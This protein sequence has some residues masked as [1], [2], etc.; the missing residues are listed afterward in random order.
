MPSSAATSS[1]VSPID[2]V[3]GPAVSVCTGGAASSRSR[4]R[5]LVKRQPREVSA[6]SPGFAHGVPGLAITQGAR[7]MDSIPPATTTS[8]S[9]ARIDCAAFATA[10]RP[11][12]QRR[13]TV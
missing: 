6:T 3:T 11:L 1:A 13:L 8:A 5:G 4:K 7:V 2:S 12:A 10:V 9:P